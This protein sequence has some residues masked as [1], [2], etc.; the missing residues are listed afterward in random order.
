M[1]NESM[2]NKAEA[3]TARPSSDIAPKIINSKSTN[4][5]MTKG[6]GGW[7]KE[8][9]ERERECVRRTVR[10][11]KGKWRKYRGMVGKEKRK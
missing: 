5:F 1:T 2:T 6:E 8:V 3:E 7:G 10:R 9:R 11:E 4:I